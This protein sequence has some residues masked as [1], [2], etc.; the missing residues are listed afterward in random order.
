MYAVNRKTKM[1][2]VSAVVLTGWVCGAWAAGGGQ[3]SGSS[4]FDMPARQ[5]TPEDQAK[6]AYNSG[7]KKL[8]DAV[9]YEADAVKTT[10]AKKIE[11]ANE[12][13]QKYYEKAFKEF[14]LAT[15]KMPTM[16]EAWNYV[17][18]T[19]R[20]LGHYDAALVAYA[21]ALALKPNYPEALEYRGEAFL[22]LNALEDAKQ[23]YLSLYRNAPP[24]ATKLMSAMRVWLDQ[25]RKEPS[26]VEPTMLDGFAT[27]IKER[28]A[29][30]GQSASAVSTERW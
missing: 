17:G 2:A 16:Y 15:E 8:K 22:G 6:Q 12:K 3:M 4:N 24:L 25:H 30:A 21:K 1:L 5:M 13:A 18:F 23:S 14:S 29:I 28:E 19:Q 7:V 27:W 26:T 20:H 11:R 10:D 9:E